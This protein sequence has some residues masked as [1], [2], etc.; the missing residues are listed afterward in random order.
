MPA[1]IRRTLRLFERAR[2]GEGFD[3]EEEIWLRLG[4]RRGFAAAGSSVDLGDEREIQKV[5]VDRGVHRDL[6]AKL[7]RVSRDPRDASLRIRFSFG[8]ERLGDWSEDE[9]RARAADRFAAAA[10]PECRLLDANRTLRR[11]LPELCGGPSRLSERI[12]FS[13]APGGGAVFHHDAEPGQRGVVFAQLAGRTAW[14]ALPKR[15]LAAE[16]ARL[17]GG[18]P[19][20][21]MRALDRHAPG[22]IER[23]L[24]RSRRLTKALVASGDCFVLGPGDVL[25]LPSH[26]PD[27]VAWH[28]VFGLGDR[29]SL[30][31]SWGLFDA[32]C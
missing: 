30:A 2:R 8:S 21:A 23:L 3:F 1:A 14:L 31:H 10:F 22:G 20:A 25:L 4:N 5:H 11:V 27:D 29:P 19:A 6:W 32:R 28:S 17:A 9:A 12:V 7:S 24:N 15:R 26:G 16:V 18:R 13:N